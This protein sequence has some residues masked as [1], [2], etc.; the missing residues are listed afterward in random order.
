MY[1]F[2][3]PRTLFLL[4]LSVSLISCN[5]FYMPVKVKPET[6][7]ETITQS[8]A[9]RKIFILRDSS[10]S[11]EMKNISF[12]Q[13]NGVIRCKLNDLGKNHTLYVNHIDRK[14]KYKA[15]RG[16]GVVLD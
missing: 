13:K 16:Q 5:K 15:S 6:Q 11:Y 4:V 9:S 3:K 7:T 1:N 10:G 14:Y 2:I 12:D 8:I